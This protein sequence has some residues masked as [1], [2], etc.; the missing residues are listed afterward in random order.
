MYC[1]HCGKKLTDDANVCS[2]CGISVKS[3]TESDNAIISTTM[4][5][6]AFSKKKKLPIFVVL[7]LIAIVVCSIFRIV[8]YSGYKSFVNEYFEAIE[9]GDMNEITQFYS[10]DYV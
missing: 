8:Q 5:K 4:S 1:S 6:A 10:W 2:A 7:P 3:T 9:T